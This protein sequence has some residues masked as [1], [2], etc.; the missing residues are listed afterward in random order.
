MDKEKLGKIAVIGLYFILGAAS[1]IAAGA[2]LH[3]GLA[4]TSTDKFMQA[5]IFTILGTFWMIMFGER[6][7][8][9]YE[10]FDDFLGDF[11]DS[12]EDFK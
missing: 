3:M 4:S 1:F 10:D 9:L 11:G 7:N 12:P 6:R 2:F 5:G 8:S